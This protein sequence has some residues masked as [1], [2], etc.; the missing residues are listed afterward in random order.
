MRRTIRCVRFLLTTVSEPTE[1]DLKCFND[2]DAV[3]KCHMISDKLHC[4]AYKLS[5]FHEINRTYSCSFEHFPPKTC[6]CKFQVPGFVLTETFSATLY[7]GEKFVF[8]KTIK[9]GES[10]KPKPPTIVSVNLTENGNFLITWDTNYNEPFSSSLSTKLTYGIKG[11]KVNVSEH[12][13][14][15]ILSRLTL[16]PNSD[17]VVRV[18]TEFN[19]NSIFSDYSQPYEF[20]TRKFQ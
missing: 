14:T 1:S 13:F 10:I 7:R 8:T 6:E 4:P 3:M 2:Y 9:T 5:V 19:N 11:S 20:R 15:K 17:Y 12:H 16:Q 18:R